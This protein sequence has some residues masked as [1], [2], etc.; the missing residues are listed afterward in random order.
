M[1]EGKAWDLRRRPA[2]TRLVPLE[3][4]D[5]S[6]RVGLL[7]ISWHA[8]YMRHRIPGVGARCGSIVPAASLQYINDVLDISFP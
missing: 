6:G 7:I 8:K 2:M 5:A 3:V 4:G 1:H